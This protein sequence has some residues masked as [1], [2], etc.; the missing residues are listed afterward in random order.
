VVL[1]SEPSG[2]G[3]DI[4]QMEDLERAFADQEKLL[5][6][7]QKELEKYPASNFS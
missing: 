3:L 7:Y 6:G 2:S 5:A 1:V 4:R